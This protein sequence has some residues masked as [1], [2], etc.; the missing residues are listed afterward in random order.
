MPAR[1]GGGVVVVVGG[2]KENVMRLGDARG[3]R[4]YVPPTGVGLIE[5]ESTC[6]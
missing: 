4:D 1:S 5:A 3:R 2:E 6:G